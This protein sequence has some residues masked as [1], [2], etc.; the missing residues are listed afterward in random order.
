MDFRFFTVA[1]NKDKWNGKMNNLPTLYFMISSNH[2][3]PIIDKHTRASISNINAKSGGKPYVKKTKPE[4][5][6]PYKNI[7]DSITQKTFMILLIAR[8][9]ET[10]I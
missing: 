6:Q 3:Y 9:V 4:E 8:T 10:V 7:I 2:L 1:H 5:L